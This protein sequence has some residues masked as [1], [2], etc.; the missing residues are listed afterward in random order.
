M[1]MKKCGNKFCSNPE[2]KPNFDVRQCRDLILANHPEW[3]GVCFYQRQGA[4]CEECHNNYHEGKLKWLFGSY[5][6]KKIMDTQICK[7][8]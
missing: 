6:G 4:G 3:S 5:G 2:I 8:R 7:Y 1:G